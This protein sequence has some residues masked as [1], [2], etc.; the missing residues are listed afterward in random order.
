MYAHERSLVKKFQDRPFVLLG[1]NTDESPDVLRA[2]QEKDHLNW[3]SWWD[4]PGGPIAQKWKVP[5]LPTLFLIDAK[6]QV[7]WEHAGVPDLNQL[8]VLI[9]QLVQEAEAGQAKVASNRR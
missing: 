4:G 5:G 9:E 7:R 6:G 3:R 8:D 2:A 1:V